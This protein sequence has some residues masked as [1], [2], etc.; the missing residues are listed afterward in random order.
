MEDIK[1]DPI[2]N[3]IAKPIDVYSIDGRLIMRQ[4]SPFD[5]YGRLGRGIY[6]IGNQKVI[7]R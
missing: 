4:V 6:I 1:V 2:D 3:E 5:A 7:K